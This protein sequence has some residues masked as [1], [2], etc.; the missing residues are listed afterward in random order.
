MRFSGEQ[1]VEGGES[2]A[3]LLFVEAKGG[4]TS[5]QSTNAKSKQGDAFF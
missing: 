1:G 2:S 3:H 5:L 4:K